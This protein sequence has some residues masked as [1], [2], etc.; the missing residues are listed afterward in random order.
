MIDV[1]GY[2]LSTTSST[3]RFQYGYDADSNVLY[4]DNRIDRNQSELYHTS[5]SSYGYDALNRL[6]NF[7]R[8]SLSA[9]SGTFWDS[10]AGVYSRSQSW[11]LDAL[12]NMAS[13]TSDGTT[14]TRTTNS[15]NQ[16][17]AISGATSPTYDSNGNMTT[18]DQNH[19]LVYDA[20]NRLVQVKISGGSVITT[21]AY[22][23]RGYRIKE[24]P[25]GGTVTDLYYS[26]AWQ[27][28]E[29]RASGAST[30]NKQYVWSPVYVDALILRDANADGN[31]GTGNLGISGS[32][33]EQR[34]YV[35]QD[36]NYNVTALTNTSGVV[37]ERYLYDPYGKV[38]ITNASYVQKTNNAS[39]FGW[40][41]LFQGKRRDFAVGLD[42]SRARVYNFNLGVWPTAEPS[43]GTYVDGTNLYQAFSSDPTGT[44]DPEG[45]YG[46]D[47]HFYAVYYLMRAKG[48]EHATSAMVAG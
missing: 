23:G 7:E 40:Q 41:N 20:W 25:N 44:L 9:A 29:E 42:E 39:D 18:D 21:Y 17:T 5:G 30:A 19:T 24:S 48:Y 28:I 43:G 31:T 26:S 14:Q 32:G 16:I 27:V 6:S 13:V 33:L 46:V 1:N 2:Q 8:G 35:Q 3:D 34:L 4:K 12:G 47:F 10:L 45:R 15:Q 11:S 22:D 38:T 37:Q 36:A